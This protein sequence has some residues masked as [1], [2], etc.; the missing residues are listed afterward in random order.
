MNN[1]NNFKQ[2]EA[3]RL[4]D[5]LEADQQGIDLGA[6]GMGWGPS[7]ATR[8]QAAA[9]LRRLY[10]EVDRLSY[11]LAYPDNFVK[12][13][14]AIDWGAVHEKLCEVWQR[15][16]SADE[17]LDEIQDLVVAATPPPQRQPLTVDEVWQ[18]DQLMSLNAEL[19]C[20]LDLLMEVART[21]E[22][23]HGIYKE[24]N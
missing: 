21:I 1:S 5:A 18:N 14:V 19:G 23:A 24:E 4:A 13:P 2:P 7:T 3:L 12:E 6:E 17:G 8:T 10:A 16:I 9:E 22:A 20:T 15:E 11:Q